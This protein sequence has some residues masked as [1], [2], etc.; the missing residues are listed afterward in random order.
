MGVYVHIG[1]HLLTAI[2]L[3]VAL[4]H[5]AKDCMKQSG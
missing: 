3:A 4:Y 2:I 5:Y 1:A